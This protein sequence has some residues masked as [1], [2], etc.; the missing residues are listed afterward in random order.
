MEW[1][2]IHRRF[3]HRVHGRVMQRAEAQLST[4]LMH[5]PLV[6]RCKRFSP[7]YTLLQVTYMWISQSPAGTMA[8]VFASPAFNLGD[9]RVIGTLAA[10]RG[11]FAR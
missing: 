2:F 3:I 1:P 7:I 8:A 9:V 6:G 10:V 11:A 4:E 5:M